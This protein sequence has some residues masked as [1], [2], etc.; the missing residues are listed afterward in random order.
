MLYKNDVAFCG[1]VERA[2]RTVS[3]TMREKQ[4][5]FLAG[6][7]V[8]DP[9]N[10]LDQIADI[11]I[12]GDSV[13]RVGTGL[14]IPA[15]ARV[16]DCG[17]AAVLPGLIDLHLHIGDLFDV[18]K[19]PLFKAADDGVTTAFSPGAGNTFMAPALLGAEADRGLPLN[20]GAF[21]GAAAATASCLSDDELVS[22][23]RGELSQETAGQK[24]SRNG[25]TNASAHRIIGIKEH[26][27]HFIL[28][29]A[30]LERLFDVCMRGGVLL[31]SHTQDPQ[32]AQRLAALAKGRPLHLGH[33]TAAGCG[34]HAD[35]LAGM[36]EVLSLVDGEQ[37]TAEFVSSMLLE[38]RGRADGLKMD[39]RAREL[40][41]Q[42][43]ADKK[44]RIL[45]SDGQSGAVM[46][47][48]GD[49][50]DDIPAILYLADAGVLSMR[51]AVSTM[52]SEPAALLSLR[53]GNPFFAQRLGHLGAGALANVTVADT[54]SRRAVYTV[55]NG[56]V[57]SFDGSAVRTGFG[58]GR[59]AAKQGFYANTGVGDLTL[60]RERT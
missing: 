57:V 15:G 31:M 19:S 60:Y 7:R 50:A 45:V 17:G 42:A 47:G 13:V 41:L 10:G 34:T 51:D 37:I 18:Y 55:V 35:G 14:A 11:E 32:H 46:K 53:T 56:R 54:Q 36:R 1:A 38:N 8:V 52:T 20:V 39:P 48:F 3:Q 30:T 16:I 24:L 59:F 43:L 28:P 21:V 40:A 33:A 44:V 29:D 6:G 23:L 25:I 5:L 58:A 49:S 9:K 2:Q 27:G 26:M 22:L 4:C 12:E